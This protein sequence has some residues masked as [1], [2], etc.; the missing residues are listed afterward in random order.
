MEQEVSAALDFLKKVYGI[1]GFTFQLHLSTVSPGL[2]R[3]ILGCTFQL[4]RHSSS[5]FPPPRAPFPYPALPSC[6][7]RSVVLD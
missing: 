2:G 1:F 7:V 6:L 5:G 4:H 3:F